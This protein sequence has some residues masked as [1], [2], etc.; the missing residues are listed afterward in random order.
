VYQLKLPHQHV[1]I[2]TQD[3]QLPDVKPEKEAHSDVRVCRAHA[4]APRTEATLLCR[5]LPRKIN[6][7]CYSPSG[8]WLQYDS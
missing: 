4:A 8:N 2:E 7:Q 6:K 3:I 5:P 1:S